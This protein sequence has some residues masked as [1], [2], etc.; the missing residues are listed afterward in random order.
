MATIYKRERSP[1]W[2]IKFVDETGAIK[3]QSTGCRIKSVQE[4]RE[5]RKIRAQKEMTEHAVSP[6]Q[7]SE[8]KL[9][10]WVPPWLAQ[11]Y[12]NQEATLESY[13]GAF[14]KLMEYFKERGVETA[15]QITRELCFAYIDWRTKEVCRNTAIHNMRVLRLVLNEAINRNLVGKNPASKMGLKMDVVEEKAEITPA[16]RAIVESANL[17]EW[18]KISWTIAINQ[19]CRL[20]ETAMPLKDVDFD[21]DT[22]TFTLKGGRRHTTRLLPAVKDLMLALKKEGKTHTWAFTRNASRGWSRKLEDLGL[23]FTF[24]STRVTVITR[25]ARAGVNQQQ[26]I[27]FIG[28]C[29]SEVHAIYTR[30]R[31]VDLDACVKALSQPSKGKP[32]RRG[33]RVAQPTTQE[34][35]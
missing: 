29:S 5:A 11:T 32:S 31:V 33:N 27:R 23:K 13:L 16:E 17:K 14:E 22:I 4:T 1:F 2:W 21:N 26:A 8:R 19:G 35:A 18:Q 20:A 10:Q 3:Q 9:S 15:T 6:I 24:H 7:R 25:L 12:K 28:H 34:H 30:L